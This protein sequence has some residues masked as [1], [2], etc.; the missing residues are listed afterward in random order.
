MARFTTLVLLTLVV[1]FDIP[2]ADFHLTT[3][4]DLM[5]SLDSY[6]LVPTATLTVQPGLLG[7]GGELR[8][9]VSVSRGDTYLEAIALLKIGPAFVGAGVTTQL[10]GTNDPSLSYPDHPDCFTMRLGVTGPTWTIGPGKLGLDFSC[11]WFMT[12]HRE[13]HFSPDVSGPS[14][15]PTESFV[16]AMVEAVA[17][18]IALPVYY[19]TGESLEHLYNTISAY[20]KFSFGVNY[21]ISL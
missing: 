9:P 5:A 13:V 14:W 12:A 15:V 4:L 6:Y 1:V 17:W 20:G 19:L 11:D 8:L 3:S 21:T 7:L 16:Q 2:A 18:C 10:M